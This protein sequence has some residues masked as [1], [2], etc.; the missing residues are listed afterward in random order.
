MSFYD[1]SAEENP[2]EPRSPKGVYALLDSTNPDMFDLSE[3]FVALFEAIDVDVYDSGQVSANSISSGSLDNVVSVLEIE[4]SLQLKEAF[5]ALFDPY[6]ED[7][8]PIWIKV[9]FND[10]GKIPVNHYLNLFALPVHRNASVYPTTRRES[11]ELDA[12]FDIAHL[13]DARENDLRRALEGPIHD[14]VAVYDVGQGNCNAVLNG[15]GIPSLY[16]DFGGGV[17]GHR[18][19]YPKGLSDFC[20]TEFPSIVLSHWDWD[21]WSSAMR[22]RGARVSATHCTVPWIVPRQRLGPVHRGFLAQLRN[23]LIW[24]MTLRSLQVGNVV[25]CR[26]HGPKTNRNHSG[27][28]LRFRPEWSL[29]DGVLLTGDCDYPHLPISLVNGR[30]YDVIVIPHHGGN[31]RP[32]SVPPSPPTGASYV[33]WCVSCGGSNQYGHP[34]Q[35]AISAH[36]SAGWPMNSLLRTCDRVRT[37]AG[38]AG[39]IWIEPHRAV[40]RAPRCCFRMCQTELVQS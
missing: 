38:P 21:H 22:T 11:T 7:H 35:S 29:G 40:P 13:D 19:T 3:P 26:C 37:K 6:E 39:H 25:V 18:N 10:E 31:L 17:L 24:P 4:V 15:C 33:R 14:S 16:F 27:L 9:L 23:F 28:A 36:T 2:P 30:Q 20:F 5:G 1:Y 8:R 32:R 34:S 12:V